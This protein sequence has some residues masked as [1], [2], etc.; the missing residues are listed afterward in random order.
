MERDHGMRMIQNPVLRGFSP[1]P[2]VVRVGDTYYVATSTFEWF[3]GVRIYRTKDLEHYEQLP[4][5]REFSLTICF[6]YC[7]MLQVIW[8]KLCASV[9]QR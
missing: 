1:D 2:S 3:P 9:A 4:H 8:N 5:H 6:F 7:I